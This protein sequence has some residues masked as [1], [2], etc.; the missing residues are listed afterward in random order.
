MDYFRAQV[1]QIERR[2]NLLPLIAV[3]GLIA[4]ALIA[5]ATLGAG[6]NGQETCPSGG[7]WTKVD[8]LSG[9]SYTFDAPS[10]FLI[11]EV[12]YKHS[13][14]VHQFSVTPTTSYTVVADF[15]W[16]E[17][18]GKEIQYELSHASFRLEAEPTPTD[19]PP[20]PTPTDPPPDP[21]PTPTD[22]PPDPTPTPT[23]EPPCEEDCEPEPTP[24]PTEPPKCVLEPQ[25]VMW[26]LWDHEAYG[27]QR[28]T[29]WVISSDPPSVERQATICTVCQFYSEEGWEYQYQADTW[30]RGTVYYD[31]CND[32]YVFIFDSGTIDEE[33]HS[34]WFRHDFDGNTRLSPRCPS[35]E[36]Q[37]AAG[38]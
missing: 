25:Y 18:A 17:N 19:E 6:A 33:W 21:T 28:S 15:H 26:K 20:T 32:E 14:Y 29:C 3:A 35:C 37:A 30:R 31:P 24:T 10:G 27:I 7:D 4:F 36:E 13:T 12:C 5:G 16:N 23:D 1:V 2:R 11:V 22:P 34:G 38:G 9:T 8:G